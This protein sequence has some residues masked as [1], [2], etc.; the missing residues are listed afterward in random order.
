MREEEDGGRM[1]ESKKNREKEPGSQRLECHG[2][3]AKYLLKNIEDS[4]AWRG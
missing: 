4:G 3:Q 1:T 2:T